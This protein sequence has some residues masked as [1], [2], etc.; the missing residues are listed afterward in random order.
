MR[1]ENKTRQENE[2]RRERD[3]TLIQLDETIFLDFFFFFR[4][5]Q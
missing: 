4:D 1:H 2:M 5:P 3:E